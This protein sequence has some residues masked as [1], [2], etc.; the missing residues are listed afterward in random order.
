M[1]WFRSSRFQLMMSLWCTISRSCSNGS[2]GGRGGRCPRGRGGRSWGR[3]TQATS[4]RTIIGKVNLIPFLLTALEWLF[5]NPFTGFLTLLLESK[6]WVV[7]A[8]RRSDHRGCCDRG[9]SQVDYKKEERSFII[10]VMLG[11]LRINENCRCKRYSL[12]FRRIDL[13]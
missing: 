1:G 11:S 13:L 3:V 5:A 2:C 7:L 10:F 8:R 4:T 9:R 6:L 12:Q